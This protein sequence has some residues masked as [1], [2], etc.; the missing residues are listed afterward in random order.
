M[1]GDASSGAAAVGA[2]AGAGKDDDEHSLSSLDSETQRD[3]QLQV[4]A[5]KRRASAEVQTA[6]SAAAAAA[7][8]QEESKASEGETKAELTE[9]ERVRLEEE[10]IRLE[11]EREKRE[12]ENETGAELVDAARKGEL[13]Q[14]KD[15]IKFAQ[16]EELSVL[17]YRVPPLSG[18]DPAK[19]WTG[20]TALI[21]SCR[22]GQ[23]PVVEYL[24]ELGANTQATDDECK[25]TPLMWAAYMG[26]VEVLRSLKGCD[27]DARD[28]QSRTALI[29]AA[30]ED[31]VEAVEILVW[32][33]NV[34]LKD[35][36]GS[37]ALAVA[38]KI[39]NYRVAKMLCDYSADVDAQDIARRTPLM[40]AARWGFVKTT[41]LLIDRGSEV[42][43][44]D[45]TGWT[46]LMLAS[47][48]NHPRCVQLLLEADPALGV[49]DRVSGK[50][51]VLWAAE[52]HRDVTVL[53]MLLSVAPLDVLRCK[54]IYGHTAL[55]LAINVEAEA[56]LK[57]A[58]TAL[59]GSETGEK[60]EDGR[61]DDDDDDNETDSD[62]IKVEA[63]AEA[64]LK[65]AFT[66]LTCSE[67]GEKSED[68]QNDDDDDDNETDS[69]V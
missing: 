43:A 41:T 38:C 30:Q 15:I 12:I 16:E 65:D 18:A 52:K 58:F 60:S 3:A 47:R 42:D 57:D 4:A 56:L 14:V 67:T 55:D 17:E 23:V 21:S 44:R 69:D 34:D 32:N 51:A 13:E 62:T 29:I 40:H 37:S 45:K 46:A 66:A 9:E 53:K 61:D 54:D 48:W 2:P 33:S 39:G 36:S 50:N 27:H 64:L 22:A 7:A 28:A 31:H 63:E 68:G 6:P 19:H 59:T 5:A 11:E 35:A 8:A 49:R 20:A 26:H 25:M 24:L 10:R 1:V